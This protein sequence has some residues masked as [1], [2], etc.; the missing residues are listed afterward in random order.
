MI[1][2]EE[3]L[4]RDRI[5]EW[6]A[7]GKNMDVWCEENSIPFGQLK[8]RIKKFRLGKGKSRSKAMNEWL[9]VVVSDPDRHDSSLTV[10]IGNA[11]IEVRAGFDPDLL[12]QVVRSLASC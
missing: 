2:P 7:S 9:P 4:W 12:H 11:S 1:G 10:R 3:Q 6:R 5:A 8:Y